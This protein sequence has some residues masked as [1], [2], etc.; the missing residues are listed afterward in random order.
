MHNLDGT[1]TK[2]SEPWNKGLKDNE[3]LGHYVDGHPKGMLGKKAWNRGIKTNYIP[4]SAFKKGIKPKTMF[5][6]GHLVSEETITKM[7]LAHKKRFENHVY[8]TIRNKLIRKSFEFKQWRKAI[9]E[10]DKY[11]CCLCGKKSGNGHS[12]EL[13]PHHLFGFADYPQFRFEIWN[14]VTLCV[15]CHLNLHKLNRRV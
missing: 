12:V 3:Y 15:D 8:T 2:F 13:H 11:V 4:K 14:G 5:K 6:K 1:Y 9:F 10:R 7:R